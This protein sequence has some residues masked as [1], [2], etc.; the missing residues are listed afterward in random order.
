MAIRNVKSTVFGL[1]GATYTPPNAAARDGKVHHIS[2][3]V[4]NIVGDNTGSRYHLFTLPATAIILPQSLIRTDAWGFAQ[5]VVGTVGFT[6]GL[7]N[8]ARAT[9]GAGGNALATV[10]AADWNSPLWEQLGMSA[11]PTQNMIDIEAFTIA[12]A[13]GA[14]TLSFDIWFAD[15][16]D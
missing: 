4:A 9:G 11:P 8:V 1:T 16:M 14:G 6:T 15:H 12:D 7:L 10:F 2:G 13:T 5:A 3:T